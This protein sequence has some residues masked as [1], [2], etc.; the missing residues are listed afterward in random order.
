[1]REVGHL[2]LHEKPAKISTSQKEEVKLY[3]E[4]EYYREAQE[5]PF[6]A[7]VYDND[8][9]LWA[10]KI[11]YHTAL[12]II[13]RKDSD[14]S[15]EKLFPYFDKQI[16]PSQILSADLLLRYLP[17]LYHTLENIDPKDILLER[18]K[19]ILNNWHYS[20][21]DLHF[22]PGQLNI[23]LYYSNS[24]LQQLFFNRIVVQKNQ[25]WGSHPAINK[26]LIQHLGFY[27]DQLWN[28]LSAITIPNDESE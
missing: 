3:L 17:F 15:I 24:C 16:Q 23:E 13:F 27:K 19:S 20:A 6:K 11:I 26:K 14:N 22:S 12:F 18:L 8:A 2:F 10:A 25:A 7:P 5:Y 1:M 21:I 9:A 28:S 4:N